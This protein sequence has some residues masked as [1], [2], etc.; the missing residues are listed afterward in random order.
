MEQWWSNGIMDAILH[1]Y[2]YNGFNV[3]ATRE[4]NKFNN[5]IATWC[6]R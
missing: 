5:A 2:S 6:G 3:V 1:W 4:H